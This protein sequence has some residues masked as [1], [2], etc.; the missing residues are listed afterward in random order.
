MRFVSIKPHDSYEITTLCGT[1]KVLGR[2]SAAE[3]QEWKGWSS[4]RGSRRAGV[5]PA[6]F[7]V[8]GP[9]PAVVCGQH[10]LFWW[11]PEAEEVSGVQLH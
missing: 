8:L 2:C 10:A 9:Q 5:S 1:C 11:E 7:R 4:R 3:Q 6:T